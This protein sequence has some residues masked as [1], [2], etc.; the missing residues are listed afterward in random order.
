MP[1]TP[2]PSIFWSWRVSKEVFLL[3]LRWMMWGVFLYV[4]QVQGHVQPP[5]VNLGA[6]FEGVQLYAVF[7]KQNITAGSMFIRV[8]QVRKHW[9]FEENESSKWR[10]CNLEVPTL[11]HIKNKHKSPKHQSQTTP[12]GTKREAN[13]AP[14]TPPVAPLQPN[15][16][17]EQ[18]EPSFRMRLCERQPDQDGPVHFCW[19]YA[20]VCWPL[21]W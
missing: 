12:H 9:W 1:W 19:L 13:K 4:C 6:L 3:G 18:A 10:C 15:H 7:C 17:E 11:K 2:L 14:P 8:H 21:C 16:R 20:D 5:H